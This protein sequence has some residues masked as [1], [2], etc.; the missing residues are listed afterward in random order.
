MSNTK[1]LKPRLWP[2]ACTAPPEDLEGLDNFVFIHLIFFKHVVPYSHD[3]LSAVDSLRFKFSVWLALT[4][5]VPSELLK[6]HVAGTLACETQDIIGVSRGQ[7]PRFLSLVPQ[8][9]FRK[10]DNQRGSDN[11][12]GPITTPRAL[13]F[14]EGLL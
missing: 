7:A 9:H 1:P 12:S 5:S 3:F 14:I 8:D 10:Y 6:A 11:R 2:P 4:T 13:G